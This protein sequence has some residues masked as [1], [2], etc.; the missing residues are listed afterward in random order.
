MAFPPTGMADEAISL[1]FE[2]A[3]SLVI[4]YNSIILRASAFTGAKLLKVCE[5][6]KKVE[7]KF[8]LC[9]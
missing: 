4:S 2:M 1:I 7:E 9:G 3:T 8:D 6:A 5:P